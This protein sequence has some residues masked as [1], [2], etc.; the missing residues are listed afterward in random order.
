MTT[1]REFLNCGLGG[2]SLISL[3]PTV[4]GFL[5][6]TARATVPGKDDRVLVVIQLDGGNDGINTIVPIRDEGY[7]RHRKV[8]RLADRELIKVTE[9][10]ALNGAMRGAAKL[11]ED[12]RLAVVQG[13]GYP[14]PNRSHFRS[15]AIWHTARFDP[16]EHN[17]LGWLGRGLDSQTATTRSAIF[18]GSGAAPVALRGRSSSTSTLERLEDFAVTDAARRKVE[19][20]TSDP[21]DDLTAFARRSTL[22]AYATAERLAELGRARDPGSRYP[23]SQLGRRLELVARLL[24]GG[25]GARVFY[26]SQAGYDTHAAQ[27]PTHGA[28]LGELSAALKAFLDDL[29]ASGLSERVAVLSFSE[30]GRR[31]AENGSS[32]TDHGTAGPVLLAGAGVK[33]GF[34]E[35]TPSLTDLADGDVKMSVDFRRVYATVL[36]RWLN[37]PIAPALGGSFESLPLFR[38]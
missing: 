19:G 32:G 25:I 29:A 24:K 37:L 9:D 27:L 1:R 17:G 13:V 26:T 22:D 8:L 4:P 28:L 33:A 15:M 20:S 7:A 6:Q 5:A 10:V 18:V 34:I 38:S 21:G 11:I 30:F 12:G 16:E 3:A 2:L 36:E 35:K 31:V 23:D 14:N